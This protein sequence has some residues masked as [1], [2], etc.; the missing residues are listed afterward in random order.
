MRVGSSGAVLFFPAEDGKSLETISLTKSQINSEVWA[1]LGLI[2]ETSAAILSVSVP[3]Y[4]VL[5]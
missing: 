2:V 1:G 5:E 3:W 4:F